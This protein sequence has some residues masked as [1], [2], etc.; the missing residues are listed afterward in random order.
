MGVVQRVKYT[1]VEVLT[2]VHTF[3]TGKKDSSYD[4]GSHIGQHF[5]VDLNTMQPCSFLRG[6]FAF[7][8]YSS[9]SRLWRGPVLKVNLIKI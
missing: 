5:A 3:C 8:S 1:K 4:L 6:V 2:H 7:G 9:Y